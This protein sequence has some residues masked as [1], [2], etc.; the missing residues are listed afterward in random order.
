[1][2][3]DLQLPVQSVPITTS[4]V[5]SN[6]DHFDVYSIHHCVIKVVSDLRQVGRWFS[7]G[8]L[9]SSSNK[10]GRHDITKILLK[11]ALNTIILTHGLLQ[12]V[13]CIVSE[14]RQIFPRCYIEMLISSLAICLA[15]LL[16]CA[17]RQGSQY[18]KAYKLLCF[19]FFFDLRILITPLVSSNSSY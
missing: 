15:S 12:Y 13:C 1:M 9:V 7:P 6:P 18:T 8:T 19:L 14:R 3:L 11:V 17:V 10:S 5:S 2:V 16:V 4:V